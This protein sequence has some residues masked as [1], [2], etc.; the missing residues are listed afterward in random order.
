MEGTWSIAF[1]AG[2]NENFMFDGERDLPVMDLIV[3]E[4]R[5][6][7]GLEGLENIERGGG[8]H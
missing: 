1:N 7:N 8:C 2:T 4:S 3:D 6:S 5:G